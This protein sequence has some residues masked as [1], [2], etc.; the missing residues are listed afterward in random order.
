MLAIPVWFALSKPKQRWGLFVS[1]AVWAS[2]AFV[3]GLRHEVGGDWIIYLDNLEQ[4]KG[5]RFDELALTR[6]PAYELLSWTSLRF[7]AG[8]Y[9]VNFVCA[10]IFSFGLVLFCREQP[11]PWLALCISIPYLVIVVAMG[12][13]RQAVSIGLLMPALLSLGSGRLKSFAGWVFIAGTFQQT[14]L[15][16]LAFL[17]PVMPGRSLKVRLLRFLIML[18]VAY[19]FVSLLLVARLEIF[20]QGYIISQQMQSEGAA[21]RIAM[22]SIP[23]IIFLVWGKHLSLPTQKYRLW[24]A[25]STLALACVAGLILIPSSTVVDRIALYA[26]PIQLFVSSNLADMRLIR[27][28]KRIVNLSIV[29]FAVVV[30]FVW[31]FYANTAF[32]WLPY[33]NLLFN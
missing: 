30:Q 28:D 25:I 16:T 26:I 4:L 21:I 18:I 13:T 17:L 6:D 10:A 5:L 31:L 23:A 29:A 19:A 24:F 20:I 32:A 12:Y 15:I 14:S 9:G 2:L 11:R 33:R 3:I 7:G 27:A 8:I 22:N 1:I